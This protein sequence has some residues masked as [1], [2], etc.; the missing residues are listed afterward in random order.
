MN[1]SRKRLR[2]EA[3]A[4]L[5]EAGELKSCPCPCQAAP[6]PVA[7]VRV[8]AL[9]QAGGTDSCLQVLQAVSS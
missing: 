1:A 2:E 8:E 3:L 7:C 9:L 5:L 4:A 6:C